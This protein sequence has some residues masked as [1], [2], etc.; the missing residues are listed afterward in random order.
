M[1]FIDKWASQKQCIFFEHKWS[2]FLYIWY[3]YSAS[4][5]CEENS[6]LIRCHALKPRWIE[7]Q[8]LSRKAMQAWAAT[9]VIVSVLMPALQMFAKARMCFIPY[10]D[11]DP[12]CVSKVRTCEKETRNSMD[13]NNISWKL[14]VCFSCISFSF[15]V[16]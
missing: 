9:S 12:Q 5:L 16:F 11:S 10:W 2:F 15:L 14:R 3:C 8:G 13:M 7:L 6:V 4:Y 1:I